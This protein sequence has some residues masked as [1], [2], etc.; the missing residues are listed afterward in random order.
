MLVIVLRTTCF[1]QCAKINQK[2]CFSLDFEGSIVSYYFYYC[3]FFIDNPV[4][5]VF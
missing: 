2:L 4:I 1:R 3:I 5:Y